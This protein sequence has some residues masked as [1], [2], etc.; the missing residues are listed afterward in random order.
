[1]FIMTETESG[2]ESN[3]VFVKFIFW[4]QVGLG[5]ERVLH[6]TESVQSSLLDD[7]TD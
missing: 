7:L 6:S 3:S 2:S 5:E 4:S 1:M